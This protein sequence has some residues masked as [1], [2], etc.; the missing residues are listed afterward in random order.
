MLK[1]LAKI[2]TTYDKI[3]ITLIIILTVG[4]IFWSFF[5]I[6]NSSAKYIVIE[7]NNEMVHKIRLVKGLKKRINLDLDKGNAEIVIE[8]GRV[9]ILEMPKEICP[10]GI[11][12]DTGWV[13]NAGEM[14]VCIPNQILITI[15]TQEVNEE[16]DAIVY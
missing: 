15:E 12:S 2:L 7:Y 16:P 5:Q 14:I 13:N 3:L 6:N 10:L 11:C 4:G 9:R 8:N 1:N